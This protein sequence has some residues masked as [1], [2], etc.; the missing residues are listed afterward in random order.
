MGAM[1]N[2]KPQ[3]IVVFDFDGTITTQDTFA[4]FLRYYA[5]TMRWMGNIIL[6]FPT[7]AAYG[8]RLID[9]NTVKAKVIRRFF[10]GASVEQLDN[11]AAIF[12]KEVIPTLIRPGAQT[13][14]NLHKEKRETLYIC[15]ASISPYLKSWGQSQH[16]DN[17]LATELEKHNGYY[18][19]EID[20]WNVWGEGKIQRINAEFAQ[21]PVI[22][23]EAYGDSRGDQELLQAAKVSH[24]KPFRLT[25]YDD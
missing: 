20:G 3:E 22:I 7:F 9:R 21:Q 17:I 19:G 14:L 23:K 12:A 1:T 16:I 8:L 5:G 4:L 11:K 10:K 25:E 6:L 13:A 18:T 2:S 24:W 15:S